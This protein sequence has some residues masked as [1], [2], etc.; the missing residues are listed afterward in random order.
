MVVNA[1]GLVALVEVKLAALDAGTLHIGTAEGAVLS[2]LDLPYAL[3]AD[4]SLMA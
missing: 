3:P 1:A 4:A 2:R